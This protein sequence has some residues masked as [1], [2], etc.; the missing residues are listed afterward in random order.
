MF[1]AFLWIGIVSFIF[2]SITYLGGRILDNKEDGLM[3]GFASFAILGIAA[4]C[5]DMAKS[6]VEDENRKL[7]NQLIGKN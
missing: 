5:Y 7:M 1:K 6:K 4:I 3:L 2:S